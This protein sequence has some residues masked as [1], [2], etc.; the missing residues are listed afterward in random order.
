VTEEIRRL[1]TIVA[2]DVVEYSRLVSEDDAGT[3]TA[4]RAILGEILDPALQ[5]FG[6]RLANTAGDSFLLEF[7]H[8]QAAIGFCIEFQVQAVAR[9]ARVS[10][11][12]KIIYRIGVTV[13]EVLAEGQDIHGE[14]VNIAA[15]LQAV[16]NVEAA[17]PRESRR[18]IRAIFHNASCSPASFAERTSELGGYIGYLNQFPKLQESPAIADYRRVLELVRVISRARRLQAVRPTATA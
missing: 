4:I 18:K 9:S 13:G 11:E 5:R 15:R 12:R 3:R 2:A 7:P 10:P 17:P 14:A 16:G 1:A 8:G 6:G